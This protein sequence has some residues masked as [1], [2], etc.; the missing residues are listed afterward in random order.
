MGGHLKGPHGSDFQVQDES[1]PSPS[2]LQE[3]EIPLNGSG[4]RTRTEGTHNRLTAVPT[5]TTTTTAAASHSSVNN[6]IANGQSEGDL[7]P[8]ATFLTP[9]RSA[10]DESTE[11]RDRSGSIDSVS[12]SSM[13][14]ETTEQSVSVSVRNGCGAVPGVPHSRAWNGPHHKDKKRKG[15]RRR[16]QIKELRETVDSLKQQ[17]S[18]KDER[19][20]DLQRSAAA[21]R[22]TLKMKEQKIDR[23]KDEIEDLRSKLSQNHQRAKSIS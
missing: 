2:P 15:H 20:N 1:S 9:Q 16:E 12:I 5:T 19:I 10:E 3:V 17:L 7:P 6:R 22:Q 11:K 8:P 23:L 4:S 18:M 21:V 14:S 13:R